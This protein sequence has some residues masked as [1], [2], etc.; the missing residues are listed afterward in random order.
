MSL[1]KNVGKDVIMGDMK[2]K[3]T[4]ESFLESCGD[5]RLLVFAF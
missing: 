3:K 1:L 4:L 2:I 5:K